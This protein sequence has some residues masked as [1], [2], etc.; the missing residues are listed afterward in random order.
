MKKFFA[1][2]LGLLSLL[3]IFFAQDATAQL[4]DP[5]DNPANISGATTWGGSG[6]TAIRTIVNYFLFFL[7]LIATIMVVYG[8]FLYV[9]SAGDEKGAEKGKNILIYAATGIIIILISFA[10]I[11]T[12]LGA[13]MNVAPA[14]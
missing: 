4:I 14:A 9:T 12:L 6:R 11:N 3:G 1:P 2:S 8:G 13:G 5:M 10:L 7:G